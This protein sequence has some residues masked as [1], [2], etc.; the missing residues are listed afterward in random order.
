MGD[1]WPYCRRGRWSAIAAGR[2]ASTLFKA[3]SAVKEA[4]MNAL[5]RVLKTS[6]WALVL[7]TL[8]AW[9]AQAQVTQDW[10][11]TTPGTYGDMIALDP[12]R[13]VYVAGS[14]PWSTML[15]TK[16]SPTGAQLWRRT[17]DNPGTREQSSWV[18]VDAAGNA[19]VTGYVVAGDD[20]EPNGLIVLKY[21]PAGNLL[22]QDVI[23]AAFG[24]ALR[25]TT[26]AANNVYVLGRMWQAN[27]SGNTTHDIVTLKYSPNGTRLWL[28]SLGFDNTS[29]DAPTSMALTPGGN[30]IVTGGAVGRMLMAAYDP[31]GNTLWSKSVVA[32]TG[33][34]DVAVGAGGESY[35]V[36]GTYAPS[37]GNVFL[38]IKHD[39]AFNEVWR[40]T[41][42]V[43]HYGVRVAVDS[44][45]NAIVTGVAGSYLDW[46]T[47][48]LDPAGGL[49]WSRLY[50]QHRYNDE[51]PYFMV[52]GPDNAVY[53]T[54]QG[55][56][57]PT[58]GDLGYLRTVT[59]KYASDG[60]QVWAMTSFDSVRGVGVRLGSDNGVFV[61]GESPQT[62]FHYQ[63]S[64]VANQ[65]P[66]AMAAATT[67][68]TGPAPLVVA[69]SSAGSDDPDGSIVRYQ[70]NFGDGTTSLAAHPTHSYAAGTWSATLTVTDNLGGASISAP[71]VISV[72]APTPPPPTPTALSFSSGSVRGGRDLTATVRVSS[73]AG[74]TVTLASSNPEVAKVP[75]SVR[76]PAG[77]SSATFRVQTSRVR[78]ITPVTISATA[79][80]S[81]VSGSFNVLPR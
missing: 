24:Y 38:V 17:F 63:Q 81:T 32:S 55:G 16:Y 31:A 9:A 53:I 49:L 2:R 61:L 6:G 54:G 20:H 3:A 73:T 36:G 27:A 72:K 80:Q 71:I 22:W 51:R 70:W 44:A 57:G 46:K 77:S 62:V 28:R 1:G 30:L 56:P 29:A 21:D 75:A 4:S 59:V 42:P 19:I 67:A 50:D 74:V 26:D 48:K 11:R 8:L 12:A 66:I 13:N 18:T 15:V 79:N 43:G 45:G 78:S 64:G 65:V 34:L 76:V 47:I 14:V 68:T 52:L 25:A 37:T 69:F 39:A 33:A 23:P 40:K 5:L 35:V 58:S 10:T 60:T 41:Y 7:N